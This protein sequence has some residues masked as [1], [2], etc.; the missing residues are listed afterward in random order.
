MDT[1]RDRYGNINIHGDRDNIENVDANCNGQCHMQGNVK[2]NV[3]GNLRGNVDG[4]LQ[5]N[6]DVKLQGNV[7]S[8]VNAKLNGNVGLN[9]NLHFGL[10]RTNAMQGSRTI[11]VPID[12]LT[13]VE[14]LSSFGYPK[15]YVVFCIRNNVYE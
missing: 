4:N 13:G 5:G 3:D 8:N 9:L 12:D 14:N 6:T 2:G 15:R 7:D 10:R 1:F 11:F